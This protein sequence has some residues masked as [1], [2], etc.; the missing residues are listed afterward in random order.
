MMDDSAR[1]RHVGDALVQHGLWLLEKVASGALEGGREVPALR[2][3]LA[4]GTSGRSSWLGGHLTLPDP[5]GC[6][7]GEALLGCGVFITQ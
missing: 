3:Q 5:T 7:A 1:L 2:P 6:E 4:Q